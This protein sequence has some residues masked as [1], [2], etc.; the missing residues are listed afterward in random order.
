MDELKQAIVVLRQAEQADAVA[1]EAVKA[2]GKRV[3][4]A[5]AALAQAEKDADAAAAAKA[6]TA[7][8]VADAKTA[9]AK[10]MKPG[11]FY[12][13]AAGSGTVL[14]VTKDGAFHELKLNQL[15][16]ASPS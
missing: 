2:A 7:K 14:T 5:Q 8:A 6:E 16:E 12:T 10:R 15:G 13:E 11:A 9:A 4:D 3:T 1:A